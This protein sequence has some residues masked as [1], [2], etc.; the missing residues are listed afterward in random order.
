MGGTEVHSDQKGQGDG[1]LAGVLQGLGVAPSRAGQAG[2]DSWLSA[3][4]KFT[5]RPGTIVEMACL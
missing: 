1:A 5:A 4:E 2:G 3:A